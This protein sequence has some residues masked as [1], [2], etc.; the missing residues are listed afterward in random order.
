MAHDANVSG[1]GA[2]DASWA[3]TDVHQP[4]IQ[5][6]NY[7]APVEE[8]LEGVSYHGQDQIDA[9]QDGALVGNSQRE[10]AEELSEGGWEGNL[11]APATVHRQAPS[12]GQF[13]RLIQCVVFGQPV[14]HQHHGPAGV[15]QQ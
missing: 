15:L 11:R 6:K 14:A 10:I 13:H 7:V 2:A 1:F 4:G 5:G 12:A 3:G 9:L 8:L